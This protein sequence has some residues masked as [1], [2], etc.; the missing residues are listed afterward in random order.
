MIRRTVSRLRSSLW[1]RGRRGVPLARRDDREYREYLRETQRSQRGCIAGRMQTNFGGATLVRRTAAA[2]LVAVCVVAT[3]ATAQQQPAR[4]GNDEAATA[5]HFASIR[6]QPLL[7]LAFL[8][9][10][11]KGGD[12]HNHLSGA[13]YAESYLRWAA[14]DNLCLATATMSIMAATCDA[15]AGL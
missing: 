5:R 2:L 15:A 13:I 1:H 9:E 11:P 10:M 7:L 4:S 3:A 14:E 6:N 12:L 8:A